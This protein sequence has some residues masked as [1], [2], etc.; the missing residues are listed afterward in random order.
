MIEGS[1]RK[2]HSL[3]DAGQVSPGEIVILAPYISDSL[4]FSVMSRLESLGIP[5]H[6][7]AHLEA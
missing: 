5:A 6:R 7:I 2:I 3:I 1:A 4:R